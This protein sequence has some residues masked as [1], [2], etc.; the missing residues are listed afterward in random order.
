[1]KRKRRTTK[2]SA[3]KKMP[4][5]RRSAKKSAAK[6]TTRKRRRSTKKASPEKTTKRRR[7]AKKSASKKAVK[8]K[9]RS[10]KR[11]SAKK[12]A[13]KMTKKMA[14]RRTRRRKVGTFPFC[15]NK[16]GYVRTDIFCFYIPLFC[17]YG[18]P[19]CFGVCGTIGGN[20]LYAV[21]LR[22]MEKKHFERTLVIIKP[23]AVQ[24]VLVGEIIQRFERVG[25]KMVAMKMVRADVAT[26]EKH[27]SLDPD[28][29]RN[30]GE[31][32]LRNEAGDSDSGAVSEDDAIAAGEGY[33]RAFEAVYDCWSDS[34]TCVGRCL[35]GIADTQVGWRY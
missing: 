29:K 1:M 2:K 3:A 7:S 30:A 8:K 18:F 13:K 24:R 11:R 25:L 14:K 16:Q 20:L 9:R 31:K 27:Y 23:D 21:Y 12:A 32:Q 26:V 17:F 4:K 35:C 28:W 34:A 10:T 22:G 33:F 6:K 19:L 5:R 15:F